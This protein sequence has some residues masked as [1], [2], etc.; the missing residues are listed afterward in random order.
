MRPLKPELARQIQAGVVMDT[1]N[2]RFDAAETWR[3]Y[4]AIPL[5]SLDEMVKRDF[6]PAPVPVQSLP[7]EAEGLRRT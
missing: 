1:Y 2:M 6:V 5:T 4:P 7:R 3:R